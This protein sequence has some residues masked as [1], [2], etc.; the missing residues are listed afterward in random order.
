MYHK[1]FSDLI[2]TYD[3]VEILK[4]PTPLHDSIIFD[5]SGIT[6]IQSIL[7]KSLEPELKWEA[8]ELILQNSYSTDPLKVEEFRDQVR[9]NFR[10]KFDR[11]IAVYANSENE[12][13]RAMNPLMTVGM[14]SEYSEELEGNGEFI[15]FGSCSKAQ[16]YSNIQDAIDYVCEAPNRILAIAHMDVLADDYL[17]LAA[18]LKRIDEAES[19]ISI[20]HVLWSFYNYLKAYGNATPQYVY[21]G[22]QFDYFVWGI[23]TA[24]AASMMFHPGQENGNRRV[25][26][27]EYLRILELMN[28]GLTQNKI[29][30]ELGV[31]RITISRHV[32]QMKKEGYLPSKDH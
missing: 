7:F 2:K 21:I 25:P 5:E 8:L 28:E 9:D 26:S 31:S 13:D 15:F 14:E 23:E 24:A 27:S 30:K 20:K 10:S 22:V 19:G 6:P 16:P 11:K 1:V 17:G 29:A 3:P 18:V 32:A 4:H 12:R